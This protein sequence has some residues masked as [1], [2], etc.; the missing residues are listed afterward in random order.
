MHLNASSLSVIGI[1]LMLKTVGRQRRVVDYVQLVPFSFDTTVDA[2]MSRTTTTT[3][4][5]ALKQCRYASMIIDK[6]DF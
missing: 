1:L 3:D 6:W 4:K 2:S 5:A